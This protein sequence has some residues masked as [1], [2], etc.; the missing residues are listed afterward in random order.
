MAAEKTKQGTALQLKLETGT[1]AGGV[2]T[3]GT[4]TY[5]NVKPSTSDDNMLS[6]GTALAGLQNYTLG[7]VMR[8]DTAT[9]VEGE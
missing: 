4:R 6:V 9:L 8:R 2:T 5:S 1:T 7:A 3:Y